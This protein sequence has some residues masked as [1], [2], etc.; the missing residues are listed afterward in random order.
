MPIIM[1]LLH[2]QLHLYWWEDIMC[3]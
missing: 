2:Q 3:P 1:H